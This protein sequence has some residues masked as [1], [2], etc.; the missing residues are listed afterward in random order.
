MA[1]LAS[2][3]SRTLQRRGLRVRAPTRS[4]ALHKAWRRAKG[5][6]TLWP[7]LPGQRLGPGPAGAV[8]AKQAVT[9]PQPRP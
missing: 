2:G 5:S 6:C 8:R 3:A 4:R 9:S 7:L 1:Q